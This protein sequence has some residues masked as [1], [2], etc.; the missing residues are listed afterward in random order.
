MSL[1]LRT[2]WPRPS[3]KMA[4]PMRCRVAPVA[5]WVQALIVRAV[6]IERVSVRAL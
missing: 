5:L 3:L 4:V 6:R 1:G 2:G